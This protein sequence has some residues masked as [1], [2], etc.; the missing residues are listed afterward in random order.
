VCLLLRRVV[1]LIACSSNEL[2]NTE[3][4]LVVLRH[5]LKVLKR[6]VGRPRL[7]RRDR[8]CLGRDQQGASSSSVVVVPREPAVAPSVA[9]GARA[10]EADLPAEISGGQATDSRCGSRAHPWPANSLWLRR[11]DVLGAAYG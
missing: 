5:Q 3:V 1:W 2:L 8:V 11:R 4:E 7:R 10:T 9:P 6:Q